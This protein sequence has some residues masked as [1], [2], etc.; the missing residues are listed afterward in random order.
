[1]WSLFQALEKFR[2]GSSGP[3]DSGIRMPDRS[4]NVIMWHCHRILASSVFSHQWA[5]SPN[6]SSFFFPVIETMPGCEQ[7][8]ILL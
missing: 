7:T 3:R 4:T 8:D 2:Y 6:V 1:M 5:I